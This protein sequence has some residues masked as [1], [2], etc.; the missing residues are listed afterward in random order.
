MSSSSYF[1]IIILSSTQISAYLKTVSKFKK[2]CGKSIKTLKCELTLFYKL[3]FLLI[4]I[5]LKISI[6][7]H[8][9]GL[10]FLQ[11]FLL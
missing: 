11:K 8:I 7:H 10:K 3:I 9:K 2:P 6:N 4:I 5:F 1:N